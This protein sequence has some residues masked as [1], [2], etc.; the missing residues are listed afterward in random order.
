MLGR[1]KGWGTRRERRREKNRE[2]KESRG[3]VIR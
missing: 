2:E 3:H 1:E